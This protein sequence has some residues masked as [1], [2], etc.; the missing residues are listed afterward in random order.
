MNTF[1][2]FRYGNRMFIFLFSKRVQILKTEHKYGQYRTPHTQSD[3]RYFFVLAI[4]QCY[5]L[6][7]SILCLDNRTTR[8]ET[9][10]KIQ[11]FRL[12][13]KFIPL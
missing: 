4:I 6:L 1:L 7:K 5:V 3:Y 2:F 11:Y 8:S 12:K 13:I 9:S 10:T